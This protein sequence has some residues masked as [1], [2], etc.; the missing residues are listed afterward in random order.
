MTIDVLAVKQALQARNHRAASLRGDERFA[1]VAAVLREGD[2]GAEVLLIRRTD[3]DGDPWSGHM[4]FPGGRSDPADESLLYTAVR[5]TFEEVGLQLDPKRDLLGRLD[6]LAAI[7][8]AHR[9]GMIIAP[10]VFA[11]SGDPV[12]SPNESEVAEVVWA[13]LEPMLRGERDTTFPYALGSQTIALPGFDVD[14]RIVWG[15]THR[16]LLEL[17]DAMDGKARTLGLPY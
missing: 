10:F 14:G 16:M 11:L 4:A 8:R 5:E 6:D 17:F 13:P 12:L 1:A 7:A 15:L 9:I 2:G 3:Q